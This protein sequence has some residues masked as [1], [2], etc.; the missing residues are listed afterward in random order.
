MIIT[1]YFNRLQAENALL[2]ARSRRQTRNETAGESS[3]PF[4]ENDLHRSP[5]RF[6]VN[7]DKIALLQ[8]TVEKQ[9][10]ELENMKKQLRDGFQQSKDESRVY[11]T[12]KVQPARE[13]D[14]ESFLAES[15]RRFAEIEKKAEQ[16]GS[17][18][19]E[20]FK[21]S[22]SA[23][24]SSRSSKLLPLDS[25][26]PMVPKIPSILKQPLPSRQMALATEVLASG[27]STTA[28][29]LKS[30]L[31][32][33]ACDKFSSKAE[34]PG[35]SHTLLL[36]TS[37]EDHVVMK[38]VTRVATVTAP[39]TTHQPFPITRSPATVPLQLPTFMTETIRIPLTAKLPLANPVLPA[40]EAAPRPT[41]SGLPD[42]F[43]PPVTLVNHKPEEVSPQSESQPPIDTS[44]KEASSKEIHEDT[45]EIQGAQPVKSEAVTAPVTIDQGRKEQSLTSNSK[46]ISESTNLSM[47]PEVSLSALPP[48]ALPSQRSAPAVSEHVEPTSKPHTVASASSSGALIQTKIPTALDD[49]RRVEK[50][51]LAPESPAS[52]GDALTKTKLRKGK[53]SQSS[54]DNSI[55]FPDVSHAEGD[56]F[57]FMAEEDF[58]AI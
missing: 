18:L 52:G 26:V 56:T 57:E 17:S 31:L 1:Y 34:L 35:Y 37:L 14:L 49:A 10:D 24:L 48:F 39:S 44:E 8:Y 15:K 46:Q 45:K 38:P 6:D 55:S 58:W 7:D 9:T 3:S 5:K 20:V 13:E 41:L 54:S 42:V 4:S 36:Q 29:T 22:S 33:Q 43:A 19:K 47:Q 2:K 50:A 23:K 12:E 30:F 25:T 27:L 11:P 21:R 16:V 40:A 53:I 51:L 32:D 28:E